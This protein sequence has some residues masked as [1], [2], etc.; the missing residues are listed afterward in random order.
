MSD[1]DQSPEQA[2]DETLKRKEQQRIAREIEI[3]DFKFVMAHKQSRRFV[4]RLLGRYGIYKSTF[5]VN[6][7]EASF[8]EGQRNCGLQ[9]LADIHQYAPERYIEL[10][11]EIKDDNRK[12]TSSGD[13]GSDTSSGNARGKRDAGSDSRGIG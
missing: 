13:T 11:T 5:S 7:A 10:L 8:N 4:W 2:A 9:L 1:L 3:D 6:H 12:H